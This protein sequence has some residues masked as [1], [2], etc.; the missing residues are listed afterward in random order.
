MKNILN[1]RSL[2]I[3]CLLTVSCQTEKHEVLTEE[4]QVSI[5]EGSEF[6]SLVERSAMHDGSQDDE[7]DQSPCFSISFPYRVIL[8]GVEVKIASMADLE[9]VLS[10]I[11][12]DV[13]ENLSLKLPVTVTTSTYEN[14]SVASLQEFQELKASCLKD[15]NTNNAP[16]T[17]AVIEFP[18]KMLVYNTG[19]QE[20]NSANIANKQQ[21]YVFLQNKASN[22]VLSFDYP[23]TVA[24]EGDAEVVVNSSAELR[25]ALKTCNN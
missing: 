1:I 14:I 8:Q 17:C 25:N 3:F 18:V 12:G 6:Y 7:L 19:T 2:L 15:I 11:S 16:I 23:I 5:Q 13:W 21:L 4:D 24:Y 22:E 20:T 10:R 9:V